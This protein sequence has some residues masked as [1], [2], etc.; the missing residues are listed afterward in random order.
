VADEAEFG[1]DGEEKEDKSNNRNS[2]TSLLQLACGVQARETSE[3]TTS[4][5]N[6]VA[7]VRISRSERCVDISSAAG[8]SSSRRPCDVDECSSE[9]KIEEHA[10]HA[11]ESDA[12]KTADE[13]QCENGVQDCCSRDTF[14]G[15]DVG[16]D[17]EVMVV[18]RCEEVRENS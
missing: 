7:G 15:F 5:R 18:K 9:S 14:H 3:P 4:L 17:V 2:E 10:N 6:S 13:Q 16:S 1:E 11:E 12:S 8:C